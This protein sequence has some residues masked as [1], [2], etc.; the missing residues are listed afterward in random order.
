MLKRKQVQ[1]GGFS[2]GSFFKNPPKGK[3]AGELIDRAGLKGMCAGGA[4]VSEKHANFI[5]NRNHATARDILAL[6]EIVQGR[7]HELFGVNLQP[8]VRVIGEEASA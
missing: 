8:E 4:V 2:A 3:T 7:V 6:M 1:P 5:V